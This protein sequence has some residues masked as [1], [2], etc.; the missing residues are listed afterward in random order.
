L[1]D[2]GRSFADTPF[3]PA[4]TADLFGALLASSGSGIGAAAK[5]LE[6]LQLEPRTW[7]AV[8]RSAVASEF[9]DATGREVL[10]IAGFSGTIPQP[11]L[12][13]LESDIRAGEFHLVLLLGKNHDPRLVWI[14]THCRPLGAGGFG[15]YLCSPADAPVAR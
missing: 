6:R 15:I 14:A 12:G 5:G 7:M 1:V 8:Y 3:E 11:T 10:P 2:E 4:S 13:Q 9:T